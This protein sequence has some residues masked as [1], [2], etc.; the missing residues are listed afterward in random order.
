MALALAGGLAACA[1][2]PLSEPFSFEPPETGITYTPVLTGAPSDEI[3]DLMRASLLVFRR[4]DQGAQ[5]VAFLRR[6]AEGDIPTAQKILRSYGYYGASIETRVSGVGAPPAAG[7]TAT[8]GSTPPAASGGDAAEGD[9]ATAGDAAAIA[10]IVIVPGAPFILAR[11][12][13][14]L[15]DTGPAGPPALAAAET[16]GSPVGRPAEAAAILEAE[17]AMVAAL[18]SAGRPYAASRGRDAV[19]DREAATLEIDSRIATGP[20]YRFGP[21]AFSGA[22]DVE[23]TYLRTY[24]PWAEGDIVDTALLAAFQRRLMGT[25]LFRAG[26]VTLPDTPPDSELAPVTVTLEQAPFRTVKAGVR[27]NTDEG[28]GVRTGLEHRNLWGANEQIELTLDATLDRQRLDA[29]F[30][31]P[32]FRRPAQDLI[33]GVELR[34]I[35]D[36]AFDELG[37]TATLGLE[38][39]LNPRWTVGAGGLL[40]YSSIEDQGETNDAVLGGLPLFV[41]HDGSDDLLDPSTGQRLRLDVTPF[42]GVFAGDAVTFLSIDA[43]ASAYRRLTGDGDVV[44]AARGRIG[45][46]IADALSDVPQTRRLYSGGG[47]SVRGFKQD[48]IGPLD[49]SG[50][51]V[52]GRSVIELGGEI[53]GRV[54]GDLGLAA[55]VDAGSISTGTVPSF[56]E[57]V[58]VAAGGGIRYASPVGPIRLDVGVPLNPRDADDSFQVYISIGQAF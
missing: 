58:Q 23:D 28:P 57:G 33:A 14:D 6:R 20:A 34:R 27:Y 38:R 15:S 22:P 1:S 50:D 47:G 30:R 29:I 32:Q 2:D 37:T 52:G 10:E 3:A 44:A 18:R 35:N 56:E 46:I 24:L 4:E 55:F 40:E 36:D 26:T 48:F 5:S 19:A 9:A 53:R 42:G 49:A 8:A 45:S 11:H 41:A 12:D 43:R 13:V 17:R 25:R 51:P 39:R 54:W 21:I 16:F 31:K 7:D